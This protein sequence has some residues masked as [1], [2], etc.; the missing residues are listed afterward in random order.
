[1][2]KKPKKTKQKLK[3]KKRFPKKLAKNYPSNSL[4]NWELFGAK[5]FRI[6]QSTALL[7][8]EDH[9]RNY[10]MYWS[11]NDFI[12]HDNASRDNIFKTEE[13]LN[14]IK[15]MFILGMITNEDHQEDLLEVAHEVIEYTRNSELST[16]KRAEMVEISWRQRILHL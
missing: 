1:M 6:R 11:L 12:N 3:L 4:Y 13:K 9:I 14:G 10:D 8:I 2:T 5:K 16:F 7:I 15:A